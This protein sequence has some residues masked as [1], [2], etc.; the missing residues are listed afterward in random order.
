MRVTQNITFE[1]KNFLHLPLDIQKI[2]ALKNQPNL[3]DGWQ[4]DNKEDNTNIYIDKSMY[5]VDFRHYHDQVEKINLIYFYWPISAPW[6]ILDCTFNNWI[7]N[8]AYHTPQ[9]L[10]HFFDWANQIVGDLNYHKMIYDFT[11]SFIPKSR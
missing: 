2:I 3:H 10:I 6:L 9:D 8:V 1:M 5:Y 7:L 4:I 11:T